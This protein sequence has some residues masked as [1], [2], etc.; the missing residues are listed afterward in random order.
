M[1]M[2]ILTFSITGLIVK[3]CKKYFEQRNC[4]S[5]NKAMN[6]DCRVPLVLPNSKDKLK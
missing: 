4:L 1:L 2:F 6:I 5:S 3:S